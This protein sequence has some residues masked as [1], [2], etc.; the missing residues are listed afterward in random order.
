M[1]CRGDGGRE[2]TLLSNPSCHPPASPVNGTI[3]ANQWTLHDQSTTVQ[4][5]SMPWK[6]GRGGRYCFRASHRLY[7]ALKN[8]GK[9]ND[10]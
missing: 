4:C 6:L 5:Q 9:N 10:M 8:Q 2:T 7:K 1:L 3:N